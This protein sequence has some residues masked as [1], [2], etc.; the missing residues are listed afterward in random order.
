M[1]L[2][3]CFD[4]AL[5]IYTPPP[6][7]LTTH[8]PPPRVV[9]NVIMDTRYIH[10]FGIVHRDLKPDNLILTTSG[11]VKLTDFGL[12]KIGIMAR[13]TRLMEEA[14]SPASIT[15]GTATTA[16]AAK[17]QGKP[18]VLPRAAI[19]ADAAAKAAAVGVTEGT[20]DVAAASA[21]VG[22]P[23]GTSDGAPIGVALGVAA[24]GSAVPSTS[25][26]D[27]PN[28]GAGANLSGVLPPFSPAAM[29][30][31]AAGHMNSGDGTSTPLSASA[32]P[33]LSEVDV[34]SSGI[35]GTPDYMAPEVVQGQA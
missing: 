17:A 4:V 9:L 19:K 18:I 21:P 11:H 2:L 6:P 8:S 20:P 29:A 23:V 1:P 22:V 7:P 13:K 33:P 10:E 5:D 12:S 30:A 14:K 3:Y 31:L 28:D 27:R 25:S 24:K 26:T 32:P 16:E 15:T 35:L 34:D